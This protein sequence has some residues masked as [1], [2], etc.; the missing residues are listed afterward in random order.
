MAIRFREH[1]TAY[2]KSFYP[3]ARLEDEKNVVFAS[4]DWYEM[5]R[6]A[7]FVLCD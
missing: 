4:G 6:F 2:S 1:Q 5:L 3:G 7:H